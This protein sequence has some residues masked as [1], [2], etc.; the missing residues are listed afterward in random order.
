MEEIKFKQ[1][2]QLED[3]IRFN[4]FNIYKINK[5]GK[6]QVLMVLCS[7]FFFG[8]PFMINDWYA[9]MFLGLFCILF[10]IVLK[11]VIKRNAKK[12]FGE[13]ELMRL[14]AEITANNDCIIE[15]TEASTTKIKW[16]QIVYIGEDGDC[17]YI[18]FTKMNA[19][20]VNKNSIGEDAFNTLLGFI[21][22]DIKRYS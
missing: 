7:I 21:P 1:T 12:L 5:L 4:M 18:F 19:F 6:T 20:V 22:E 9:L 15:V 8:M 2:L 16:D 17:L 14:E 11:P 13:T 3:Y 10:V